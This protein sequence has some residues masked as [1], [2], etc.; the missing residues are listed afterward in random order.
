MTPRITI[1]DQTLEQLREKGELR[2]EDTHGVPVVLM[3]VDA[4]QELV[5]KLDYDDSEW[6]EEEMRAAGRDQLDDP[7]GW[8]APGME[9]YDQLY[10]DK[11][12]D[13]GKNP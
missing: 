11:P 5:E 12:T 7:E 6:T 3:T 13:H 1:D 4:R 9:I 10:G 2:V 8:G